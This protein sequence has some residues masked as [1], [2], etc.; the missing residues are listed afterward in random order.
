MTRMM[1]AQHGDVINVLIPRPG[2]GGVPAPSGLGK[3]IVEFTEVTSAVKARN[4]MHGRRF[5]GRT[6]TVDYIAEG[7][8]AAGM[9]D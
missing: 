2:Q 6:V 7:A 1:C 9:L 5:A 4:S 3:V 8:Y